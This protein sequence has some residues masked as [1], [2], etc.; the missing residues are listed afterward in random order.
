MPGRPANCTVV[1]WK[2]EILAGIA[3]EVIEADGPMEP[4][5]VVQVV[6][7]R[8]MLD[9]AKLIARRLQLTG[10]FGLDFMLEEVL[11]SRT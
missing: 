9:A 4:A 10:F 1:S 2:G 8:E 11:A 7:G 6:E 3:V 5:I